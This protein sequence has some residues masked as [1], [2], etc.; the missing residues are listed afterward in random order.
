MR[1][2]NDDPE[3]EYVVAA[4]IEL[5]QRTRRGSGEAAAALIHSQFRE[6]GASGRAWDRASIL[7]LMDAESAAAP[8]IDDVAAVRL[9]PNVIQVT[10]RTRDSRGTAARSS[11]WL[12]DDGDWKIYFHQGT[13]QP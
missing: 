3:I 7:A 6:F 13:P 12:R 4:E 8:A 11:I 9:G 10:Y 1:L 5:A 2:T